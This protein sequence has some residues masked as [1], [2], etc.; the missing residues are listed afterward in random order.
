[1]RDLPDK[2]HRGLRRIT[3]KRQASKILD[4]KNWAS[5]YL[6]LGKQEWYIRGTDAG[7][8]TVGILE[9]RNCRRVWQPEAVVPNV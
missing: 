7:L 5:L 4:V 2:K 8:W 9:C 1:V 6:D 3:N